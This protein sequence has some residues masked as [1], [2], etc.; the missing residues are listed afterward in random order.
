MMSYGGNVVKANNMIVRV[1]A[2]FVIS[3]FCITLHNLRAFS[4]GNIHLGNLEI[5]PS[6]MERVE[7]DDNAFQVSNK[8]VS[9]RGP[10]KKK[11]DIINT[12]TPGLGL[13][14]PFGGSTASGAGKKHNLNLDWHSDF[15]NYRDNAKQNQQNHYFF[16]T[17]NLEFA[18]GFSITLDDSYSDTLAPAGSETDNLHAL[19]SNTGSVTISLPDYFRRFDVE[20][21]YTNFEQ[22]YDER[23]L[24]RANRNQ[25]IFSLKV[26]F[27]ISPKITVFPEY[28]YDYIEYE[29]SELSDSHSNTIFGGFEGYITSRITG[30]VKL[31][32]TSVDYDSSSTTD[33]ETVI[34][35]GGIQYAI[36]KYNTLDL[37]VSRVR[38]ESEFTTGSNAFIATPTG[39][40]YSKQITNKINAT[41]SGSYL[42]ADFR[43]SPRKDHTYQAGFIAMYNIKEW[44]T[45]DLNFSHK[46][47][48]SNQDAQ[49]ET[50][51]KASL[52]IRIA[53]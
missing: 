17:A 33:I 10:D 25:N 36:S 53:F 27:K 31:G 42:K 5:H 1:I 18:K 50:I 49:D 29:I 12:Y 2:I 23:A 8:D 47:R 44:L 4:Q 15:R 32:F 34:I 9:E 21:K 22:E 14:F 41:L 3:S 20:F 26:P 11:S 43:D 52:G 40:S 28:V 16:A 39:F 46:E 7:F 24:R 19:R 38:L 6:F 37:T 35:E 45:A 13:V 30:V 48:H 51:N